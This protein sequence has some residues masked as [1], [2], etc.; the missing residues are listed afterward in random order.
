MVARLSERGWRHDES[1]ILIENREMARY[2]AASS[3]EILC[4][5]PFEMGLALLEVMV[6]RFSIFE[7]YTRDSFV[8]NAVFM[9]SVLYLL[10]ILFIY[11]VCYRTFLRA[12]CI[13]CVFRLRTR[14]CILK[15]TI[16]SLFVIFLKVDRSPKFFSY[17]EEHNC[18]SSN[19]SIVQTD[20]TS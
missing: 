18:I 15:S 4:L 5:I 19:E 12:A 17:C 20:I 11:Y 2:R 16:Q 10:V 6:F 9:V 14:E 3:M 7:M 8:V 13:L 1:G